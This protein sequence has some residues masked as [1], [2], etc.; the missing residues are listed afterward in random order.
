MAVVVMYAWP[1][2]PRKRQGKS[3]G[4]E[5]LG[6]EDRRTPR[7]FLACSAPAAALSLSVRSQEFLLS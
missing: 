1:F 6:G 5:G 2:F 4:P 3:I 7:R